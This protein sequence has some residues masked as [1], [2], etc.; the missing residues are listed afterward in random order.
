M[1]ERVNRGEI[2]LHSFKSPDKRRP[3]LI[4][5]RSEVIPL[6][7]TVMVAVGLVVA[8]LGAVWL[9]PATDVTVNMMS[10]F[11]FIVVLGILVDDA[12][13]VGEN[14]YYHSRKGLSGKEAARKGTH[15]VMK[16]VIDWHRQ[17]LVPLG[18]KLASDPRCSLNQAK[19]YKG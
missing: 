17:G 3:V 12:I 6:V 13:V 11:G 2:W 4:L 18:K 7:S 16:P 8:L 9:L 14:I 15:E 5:T 1:A 10:L 19:F